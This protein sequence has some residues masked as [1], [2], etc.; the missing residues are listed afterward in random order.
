MTPSGHFEGPEVNRDLAGHLAI[1]DHAESLSFPAGQTVKL[2]RFLSSGFS[3]ANLN[4]ILPAM[5]DALRRC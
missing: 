2:E 5:A 3:R 1:C 4:N